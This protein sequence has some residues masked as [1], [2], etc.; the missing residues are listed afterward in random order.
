M[1]QFFQVE[2]QGSGRHAQ[3]LANPARADA[4]QAGLYQQAE[5]CQSGILGKC[6]ERCY[7]GF[8]LHLSK[9]RGIVAI[10]TS[11]SG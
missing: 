9:C 10:G 4:I 1:E 11:L 7:R 8:I 3:G 5:D 6:S 2:G